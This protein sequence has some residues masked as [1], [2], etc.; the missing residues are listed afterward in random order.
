MTIVN[1]GKGRAPWRRERFYHDVVSIFSDGLFLHV[2]FFKDQS[3]T[4]YRETFSYPWTLDI[5]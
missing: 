5:E 2:F 1:K 4:L 3:A